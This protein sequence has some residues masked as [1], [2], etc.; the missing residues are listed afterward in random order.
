MNKYIMYLRKSRMDNDYQDMSVEETLKRHEHILTELA[1]Y[2]GYNVVTIYR[3]VASGESIYQRPYMQQL[4]E[5]ISTG[6]YAGV[7]VMDNDRLSRGSSFESGYISQIFQVSNT[8][9]ITPAKTYDLNVDQDEQFADMKFMF[10]RYEYKAITGRMERGRKISAQEGR[11]MGSSAP[12]GYRRVKIQGDKGYTLEIVPEEAETVR[13]IFDWYIAGLGYRA[14]AERLNELGIK[15]KTGKEWSTPIVSV[16]LR[17]P[18]YCGK[19]RMSYKQTVKVIEGGKVKKKRKRNN[20]APVYDGLHQGIVP[21]EV[22]NRAQKM[23]T[24]NNNNSTNRQGVFSNYFAGLIYCKCCGKKMVRQKSRG[25]ERIL[26]LNNKCKDNM[27]APL[28]VIENHVLNALRRWLVEYKIQIEST[29]TGISADMYM[30]SLGSIDSELAKLREQLDS[31]CNFLEQ[32]VYDV[33]TFTLRS[34][35]I[36]D[37]IKELE[38]KKAELENRIA[39]LGSNEDKKDSV[40]PKAEQILESYDILT[41]EEKHRLYKELLSRIDYYRDPKTKDITIEIYPFF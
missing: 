15:T 34:S 5:D 22:F 10:S 3:E 36:Q 24:L 2:R 6:D 33:S 8:K 13:M 20:E 16:M 28:A 27:S 30:A 23:R 37:G 1:S 35:K 9:I 14:I 31:V 39:E 21:E 4:L 32:G 19:I 41:A 26:C 12:F 7:I 25:V 38:L 29:E 11:F 40:I 18:V 17:S